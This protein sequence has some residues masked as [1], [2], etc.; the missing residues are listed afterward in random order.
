MAGDMSSENLTIGERAGCDAGRVA[1]PE[2]A[3]IGTLCNAL[4][5]KCPGVSRLCPGV[6]MQIE[7]AKRPIYRAFRSLSRLF[8]LSRHKTVGVG[9]K[10][11][12]IGAHVGGGQRIH[13]AEPSGFSTTPRNGTR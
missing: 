6:N 13:C 4:I 11:H 12:V 7:N 10:G 8:R 5:T 1:V 3:T 9:R 2:R